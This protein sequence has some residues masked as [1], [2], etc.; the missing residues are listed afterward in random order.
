MTIDRIV[1]DAYFTPEPLALAITERLAD[2]GVR[3]ARILEPSSGGGAF[4]RAA[5]TT[6]SP[7]RIVAVD[8]HESCRLF[9]PGAEFRCGDFLAQTDPEGFDLVLGNPPFCDAQAHVEHARRML[10]SGG[11]VAFLLRLSFLGSADRKELCAGPGRY[12]AQIVPRPSF[13][14]D[15]A[16]DSSE[17]ALFMWRPGVEFPSQ[18]GEPL[19]W[20]KPKRNGRRAA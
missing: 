8:I 3:P 9:A 15:G 6:W 17:Y 1:S 18:L 10:R 5:R 4:V 12:V 19:T 20:A 16:T 11:I 2:L 7:A 13:T 14:S